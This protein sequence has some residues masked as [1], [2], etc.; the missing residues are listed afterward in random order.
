[1]MWKIKYKPDKRTLKKT[2]KVFALLPRKLYYAG[3]FYFIWLQYFYQDWYLR[4]GVYRIE[5]NY[6]ILSNNNTHAL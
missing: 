3:D 6:P 1:M 5:C 2:V 4:G